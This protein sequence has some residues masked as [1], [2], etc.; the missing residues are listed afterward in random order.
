MT[1]GRNV[2]HRFPDGHESVTHPPP[3]GAV[4]A[5][6]CETALV[7]AVGGA[8]RHLLDGLVHDEALSVIVHHAQ[9][10]AVHVQHRTDRF[11]LRPLQRH[12]KNICLSSTYSTR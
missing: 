7:V 4:S 5:D 3:G 12:Q 8:E 2:T 10:V 6:V 1:D 11:A 9:P